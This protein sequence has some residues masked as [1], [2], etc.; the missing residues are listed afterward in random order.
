[1]PYSTN[2]FDRLKF[3]FDSRKLTEKYTRKKEQIQLPFRE[4]EKEGARE[5]EKEREGQRERKRE[6]GGGGGGERASGINPLSA[7][8]ILQL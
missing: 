6:R 1:M 7:L 2:I 8:F 4:G 5:P 3:I